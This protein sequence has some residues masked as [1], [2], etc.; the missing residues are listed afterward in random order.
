MEGLEIDAAREVLLGGS[1]IQLGE[2][3][4]GVLP[5]VYNVV[6]VVSN[7]VHQE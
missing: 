7:V 1:N 2:C 6:K 5:R 3:L 4:L